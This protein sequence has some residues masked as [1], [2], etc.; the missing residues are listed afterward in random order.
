MSS[1]CKSYSH[2]FGKKFQHICVSLDVNFN[3]SLTNDIVSF[4]QLGPE[5]FIQHNKGINFYHSWAKSADDKLMIHLYFF[6]FFPRKQDLTFHANCL[7]RR[8][9][10]ITCS[11]QES[12]LSSQRTFIDKVQTFSICYTKRDNCFKR[13]L[14]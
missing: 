11:Q 1:F 6:L 9:L 2:F 4:E 3:E 12:I 10:S 13:F 7:H 5:I 8:V 14:F